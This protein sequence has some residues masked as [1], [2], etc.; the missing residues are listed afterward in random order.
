VLFQ[1]LDVVAVRYIDSIVSVKFGT[2]SE[3]FEHGFSYEVALSSDAAVA[4]LY[5][6]QDLTLEIGR[7]ETSAG[8]IALATQKSISAKT[9]A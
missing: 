5:S 6:L 4:A 9:F 8:K 7:H 3:N 2:A 1:L